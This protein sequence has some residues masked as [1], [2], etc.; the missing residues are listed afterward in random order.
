VPYLFISYGRNYVTLDIAEAAF[1]CSLC[2]SGLPPGGMSELAE[3]VAE[4]VRSRLPRYGL[5][6]A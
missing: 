6:P 2:F 3:E 4:D 5:V 1:G